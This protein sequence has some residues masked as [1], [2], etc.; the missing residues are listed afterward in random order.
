MWEEKE[1]G[2]DCLELR[3]RVRVADK[4]GLIVRTAGRDIQGHPGRPRSLSS[5]LCELGKG[6]PFPESSSVANLK[7][8]ER[9]L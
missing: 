9:L 6:L 8:F 4:G 2:F 3:V 5:F 1:R 7:G